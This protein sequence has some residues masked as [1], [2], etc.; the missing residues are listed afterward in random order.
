MIDTLSL[1]NVINIVSNNAA[2][3]A[4]QIIGV[5]IGPQVA[6]GE[7]MIALGNCGGFIDLLAHLQINGLLG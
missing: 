3:F 4:F 6:H 1:L 7:L 2:Q 5:D